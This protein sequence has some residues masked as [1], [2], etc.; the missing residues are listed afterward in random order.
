MWLTVVAVLA[1]AA[2]GV[3]GLVSYAALGIA[4]V[5]ALLLWTALSRYLLRPIE[6]LAEESARLAAIDSEAAARTEDPIAQLGLDLAAIDVLLQSQAALLR[7]AEETIQTNEVRYRVLFDN[8]PHPMVVFDVETLEILAANDAAVRRYGFSR[9]QFLRMTLRHLLPEPVTEGVPVVLERMALDHE[10][11]RV[12]VHRRRDGKLIDVEVSSHR[13]RFAGRPAALAMF[14]DITM[15]KLA[16]ESNRRRVRAMADLYEAAQEQS[17]SLNAV[18]V[19]QAVVRAAVERFWGRAAWLAMVEEDGSLR[20]L[21]ALPEPTDSA[22]QSAA[23]SRPADGSP[24]AIVIGQEAAAIYP[25]SVVEWEPGPW[26]DEKSPAERG[27]GIA[28]PL[29][30][31]GRVI[32]VLHVRG[33]TDWSQHSDRVEVLRSFAMHAG[34]ALANALMHERLQ[35]TAR[36]L[37]QRVR[38]RT[39]DLEAA[40]KELEAF[41]YSVSHDLRAPLRAINGFSRLLLDD[42]GEGLPDEAKHY[43]DLIRC[44]VEE[45]ETL[46]AALLSLSRTTRQPLN[47]SEVEP[48]AI[49]EAAMAALRHEIGDRQ[50]EFHVSD[51]PPCMADAVLLRQ[52]FV[53][54]L[55]NAIKYTSRREKAIIQ[56][57]TLAGENGPIYYVKD[58]GV[59]FDPA[60]AERL[61]GVFQRLHRASDYPG[62][63][64]GLATVHRIVTRHGGRIWFDAKPDEGATFYFTMGSGGPVASELQELVGTSA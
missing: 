34:T 10:H 13:M 63:G 21:T 39:A 16:E 62:V 56:V 50:V 33:T 32:G 41:S 2:A 12:D 15:R 59:G 36:W 4:A 58:N 43:L 20:L 48:R 18:G 24:S 49:A 8:N 30:S 61:F 9:Q 26:T 52:V 28:L 64:V 5:A 14:A 17:A 37:E 44:N 6:R 45:M 7:D 47:V 57:G 1:A 25:S 19:A 3:L 22:S 42:Y 27:H 46:I 31:N 54:L 51:L 11:P 35:E 55:S 40:N 29:A 38:E 60:H 53:N 23:M